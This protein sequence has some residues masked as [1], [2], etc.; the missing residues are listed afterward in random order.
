MSGLTKLSRHFGALARLCGVSDACSFNFRPLSSDLFARVS[1]RQFPISVLRCQR[2][3]SKMAETGS[4]VLGK[5][6]SF[7]R[8]LLAWTNSWAML[9]CVATRKRLSRVRCGNCKK[10]PSAAPESRLPKRRSGRPCADIDQLILFTSP[11]GHC[12]LRIR[13]TVRAARAN[14]RSCS[15]PYLSL[16]FA[17]PSALWCTVV[18]TRSGFA[19][20]DRS[21]L[22]N[23]SI[24]RLK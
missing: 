20:P 7:R 18:N 10:H 21:R 15:R 4:I 24:V 6:P 5:G 1:G 19:N 12:D 13:S 23:A 16:L 11:N 17:W 9:Q 22:L 3:G 8:Q 14:R 2:L